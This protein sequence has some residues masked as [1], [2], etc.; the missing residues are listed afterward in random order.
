MRHALFLIVLLG[1]AAPAQAEDFSGFYAGINAGYAAGRSR[2]RSVTVP[3]TASPAAA[4]GAGSDLP[5]S[6]RDAAAA[7]RSSDSRSTPAA[8]GR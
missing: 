8:P 1:L 4:V 7:L 2:D 3:G 5:P 6:A